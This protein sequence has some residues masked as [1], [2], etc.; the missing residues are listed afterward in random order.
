MTSIKV[1]NGPS[2]IRRLRAANWVDA[3]KQILSRFD[4][5]NFTAKYVDE[6]G[7][8]VTISTEDEFQ[9]AL[10][11]AT[12][13]LRVILFDVEK[14]SDVSDIPNIPVMSSDFD[15]EDTVLVEPVDETCVEPT[16]DEPEEVQPVVTE[17]LSEDSDAEDMGEQQATVE[18]VDTE[19]ESNAKDKEGDAGQAENEGD[20]NNEYKSET[21]EVTVANN[22]ETETS[23]SKATD[24]KVAEETA[25][26]NK[27][28]KKEAPKLFDFLECVLGKGIGELVENLAKI[29]LREYKDDS[30]QN[31]S[32]ESSE[33]TKKRMHPGVFCDQCEKTIVGTRYT[34]MVCPDYD[35]CDT[36]YQRVGHPEN[37]TLVLRPVP[38][39]ESGH[40]GRPGRFSHFTPEYLSGP[41]NFNEHM[42]RMGQSSRNMYGGYPHGRGV[43]YNFGGPNMQGSAYM[44]GV[45]MHRDVPVAH[46]GCTGCPPRQCRVCQQRRAPPQARTEPMTLFNFLDTLRGRQTNGS[47]ERKAADNRCGTNVNGKHE[48]KTSGKSCTAKEEGSSDN[49]KCFKPKLSNVTVRVV[50]EKTRP[51]A[52]EFVK[53]ATEPETPAK[54][55]QTP[56]TKVEQTPKTK[57]EQTPKT[58][59]EQTPKTK[60]EQT[61]ETKVEQ[62]PELKVELCPESVADSKSTEQT[63]SPPDSK[64][65]Q[66]TVSAPD[67]K[68]AKQ[69]VSADDSKSTQQPVSSGDSKGT[70][71]DQGEFVI[72]ETV[73]DIEE[74][75]TSSAP[76]AS[77][78]GA[79]T[80]KEHLDIMHTLYEMGFKDRSLN[81]AYIR[82]YGSDVSEIANRLSERKS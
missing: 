59:V 45:P 7:D 69:T 52:D 38:D 13:T 63:V 32:T 41:D 66:Q 6:D 60:V 3:K 55:E 5:Q 37:H 57:V 39:S 74:P 68:S 19:P 14:R 73:P 15:K 65:T 34:C 81:A 44:F 71:H 70:E 53:K 25:T 82:M 48:A 42:M 79:S 2:D 11:Q 78:S 80:P 22:V 49:R 43:Q 10:E 4:A 67:S 9:E 47:G 64:S 50:N 28:G 51:K 46:P 36:C 54:V 33:T 1:I 26:D 12:G 61:S 35:M 17:S 30:E 76:S 77:A 58:K 75:S 56:K 29:D 31:E 8:D 21:H 27:D 40:Y 72:V 62:S 20:V 18:A 23:G 24:T 16:V